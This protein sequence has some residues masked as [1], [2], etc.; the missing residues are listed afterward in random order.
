MKTTIT[1]KNQITLPAE[2][3]RRLGLRRGDVLAVIPDVSSG[4]IT[5]EVP[6]KRVTGENVLA[7]TA[8]MWRDFPPGPEFVK[9]LREGS[10]R[11]LEALYESPR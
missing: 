6:R 7:R 11:R 3:K 10:G 4:R 2:V 9:D 5:L 8:G 1:A